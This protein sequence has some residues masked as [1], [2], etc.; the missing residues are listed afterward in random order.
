MLITT[1]QLLLSNP[2]QFDSVLSNYYVSGTTIVVE[3]I[4][5]YLNRVVKSIRKI[6]IN[7]TILEP[8]GIYD[9]NDFIDFTGFTYKNY[10][11]SN[12]L[13]D[14]NF[15]ESLTGADIT[16]ML[17]LLDFND[18]LSSNDITYRTQTV[19][20]V[21][22]DLFNV[23]QGDII[24]NVKNLNDIYISTQI[25][26]Y[27]Q[28]DI[29]I[30]TIIA[31]GNTEFALNFGIYKLKVITPYG[32]ILNNVILNDI[33]ITNMVIN[34]YINIDIDISDVNNINIFLNPEYLPTINY[35]EINDGDD[36]SS[37][38]YLDVFISSDS[39]IDFY[40]ISTS[41]SL[42]DAIWIPYTSSTVSFYKDYISEILITIYVKLKNS[43]GV[44][45]VSSS[46]ILLTNGVH[47]SD[48][49]K[50]YNDIISAYD[51]IYD[52]YSGTLT[53][54]VTI[55]C[56]GKTINTRTTD[57]YLLNIDNFNLNSEYILTIDGTSNLIID[58]VSLGGI[59]ITHSKNIIIKN[60]NFIN[61]ASKLT[62]SAPE[63]LSAI[64]IQGNAIYPCDNMIILNNCIDCVEISGTTTAYGDYGIICSNCP[65]VVINDNHIS[66]ARATLIDINFVDNIDIVKN[67]LIGHQVNDVIGH[68]A[69]II[70]SNCYRVN[71]IDNDI[72]GDTYDTAFI[73]NALEITIK[74]NKLYNFNGESIKISNSEP[75][76]YLD[77][78]SNLFY[79]NLLSPPY[80]WEKANIALS[81]YFE[82]FRFV[83]NTCHL[84]GNKNSTA[85]E[86]LI[87]MYLTTIN[88]FIYSNNIIFFD[89]L[90]YNLSRPNSSNGAVINAHKI[91]EFESDNNIYFDTTGVDNILNNYIMN[92]DIDSP[93]LIRFKLDLQS[94]N[95]LG[96]EINSKVIPLTSDVFSNISNNDYNLNI[97]GAS[98]LLCISGDIET[99][100]INYNSGSTN[101]G[102][103]GYNY[104][105]IDETNTSTDF[106]ITNIINDTNWNSSQQIV[107]Y[108]T[109]KILVESLN[110]NRLILFKTIIT[111]IN[112]TS[113][114]KLYIGK[115]GIV[116]LESNLNEDNTYQSD[117]IYSI[118]ITKI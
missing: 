58:C 100:D 111:N 5:Q 53:Q 56:S 11:F 82:T 80:Y 62:E 92:T 107:M 19:K 71:I 93:V 74:R 63:E 10:S 42:A 115:S 117:A 54:D 97:L 8:N 83:S 64:N 51:D 90:N 2:I 70:F 43:S 94:Y 7:I 26:I 25:E 9:I 37:T 41:E 48:S 15:K 21:F 52:E 108:S 14:D 40:M 102:A 72:N 32:Y 57:K 73:I 118:D 112:D 1:S 78:S 36:I 44:S 16:N 23:T 18:K 65:N 66:G 59:K 46:S 87:S 79:N 20:E 84:I 76:K 91:N 88:K 85:Q 103:Y 55:F 6:G 114:K 68:P 28:S 113:S 77:I 99:I 116:Q 22:D 61:V 47:R 27:N 98:T 33:D 38:S 110:L 104:T 12:S 75:G 101:T 35:I 50:T 81:N 39:I 24:L 86:F 17:S 30:N 29:L 49:I 69:H 67:V 105:T 3:S 96:Y 89:Y 95:D 109:E 106:K 13:N 4:N 34:D 45:D 60:T 31:S